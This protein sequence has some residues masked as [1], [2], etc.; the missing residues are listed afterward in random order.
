MAFRPGHIKF[1]LLCCFFLL[2]GCKEKGTNTSETRENNVIL[3]EKQALAFSKL[4]LNCAD[5]EFPNKLN[6]TLGNIYELGSPRA[7]HPAFFGCFDWHSSVHG[8]WLLV[9]ILKK[10]PDIENAGEIR[11]LLE[12]HLSEE[13]I[14]R[15]KNYFLR[16]SESGFERTYGW[17]WLLKLSVSIKE[18]NDPMGRVLEKNLDPLALLIADKYKSF[19]PKLVY[20]V[21]GGEHTN[22]AFGLSFA[23]DYGR[24]AGDRALIEIIIDKAKSFY[25]ADSKCPL[26]WEPSG[27][28]FLSPCLEEAYLMKKILDNASYNDWLGA[29]LPQIKSMDFELEPGKVLDNTDGKLVHLD[30][31][32]FSRAWA[33]YAIAGKEEQYR[34]LVD[35]A[36]NHILHSLPNISGENYEGSHWLA[37]FAVYALLT[38]EE[39]L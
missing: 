8:H 22:T 24:A 38:H 3:T 6:Q 9:E 36:D 35:I 11:A 23:L 30:G 32:N 29:F 27:Y 17:A 16:A 25:M 5:Q 4:V 2:Y 26:E 15:E 21:R 13:N 19:L 33:L 10:F 39:N 31:L 12:K 20:P 34:H 14:L 18:W 1:A 37:S 7:L 28:D